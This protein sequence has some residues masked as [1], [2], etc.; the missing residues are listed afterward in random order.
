MYFLLGYCVLLTPFAPPFVASNG[1][2]RSTLGSSGGKRF[3]V[4]VQE[5]LEIKGGYVE[6]SFHFSPLNPFK[7]EQGIKNAANK[8]ASTLL[9][10]AQCAQ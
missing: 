1:T 3:L 10:L 5:G 7:S 2:V 4:C 9:D 8:C 6:Q